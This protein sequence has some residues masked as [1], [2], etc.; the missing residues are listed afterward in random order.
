METAL[1]VPDGA[2]AALPVE[3]VLHT[4]R[5][6]MSH[7]AAARVPAE[8]ALKAWE[9]DAAPGFLQSL[10]L[11]VQQAAAVDEVRLEECVCVAERCCS[12]A[13]IGIAHAHPP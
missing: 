1:A 9:S 7:D 2:V 12:V 5:A 13:C 11:I 3:Q 10:L 6:A 8:A 4:V